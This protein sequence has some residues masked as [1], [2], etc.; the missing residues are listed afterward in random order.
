M[1]VG[2][3]YRDGRVR[4]AALISCFLYFPLNSDTTVHIL[5]GLEKIS[6][7]FG[8]TFFF[9]DSG[10]CEEFSIALKNTITQC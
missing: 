7:F 8:S 5:Q 6:T 3:I 1:A 2:F 4:M 9:V 10:S